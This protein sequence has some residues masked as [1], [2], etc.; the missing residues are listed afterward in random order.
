MK[1]L[2]LVALAACGD[3]PTDPLPASTPTPTT[4]P[5]P[6]GT[7]TTDDAP[8][9]LGAPE[10]VEPPA[11]DDVPLAF[12]LTATTDR[13]TRL[14]LRIDD[15]E[16]VLHAA[17]PDL[18]TAHERPVLGAPAGREVTVTVVATDADG[19][20][21]QST[22][23]PWTTPPPPDPFPIVEWLAPYDADR[24]EPGLTF[25][26]IKSP[27][28]LVDYLVAF[29]DRLEL[30]WWWDAG[31]S[32]GDVRVDPDTGRLFG[33]HS[34]E[35]TEMDFLGAV[36]RRFTV[37][38]TEAVDRPLPT[39]PAHHEAYPLADGSFWTLCYDAGW[40][41]AYP[42]DYDRP[43]QLAY[44]GAPIADNCAAHIAADGTLL[45]QIHASDVLDTTRIGF[46]SLTLLFTGY[47]WVHLNG[48]VPTDDGGAILSARHQ[49]ALV[50]VDAAG[51]TEWILADP[52]GWSP[53]FQPLL[54]TPLGD[55]TWPYHQHAPALDAEGLLWVH[56]NHSHGRVPYTP[57]AE[58]DPEI[59][60]AVGYRIDPVARTVEQV[61]SLDATPVGPLY[62]PA[63]GDA[64]P[65][66]LT[67]NVLSDY[68]F[69]DGEGDRLNADLGYGRKSV[70]LVEYDLD[71]PHDP[72]FAVRLRSD[73]DALAEGWKM[74]RVERIPSLHPAD[75]EVW[76]TPSAR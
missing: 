30:V 71:A 1:T 32:W 51:T 29:D 7:A 53:A 56:D 14:E 59:S 74:Y 27:G 31:G 60:R 22:V 28:S 4:P 76:T 34:D 45:Q 16:R 67:G 41:D 40:A 21:V 48:V 57:E 5:A 38:P 72:P 26:A 42:V 65:L 46:D 20:S 19:R 15:G 50:K 6:T 2:L 9:F 11:G 12:V 54:L 47:D 75:V 64:D 8:A 25:A 17:F 58:A 37:F 52:A 62:S 63:L 66:P 43:E 13:P 18:A 69:V 35:P 61:A 73:V 36:H 55:V 33:I 10:L 49:G 39:G 68:A 23:G 3:G 70:V 24:A 44:A